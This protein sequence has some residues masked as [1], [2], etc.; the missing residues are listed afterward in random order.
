VNTVDPRRI[1]LIL[2]LCALAGYLAGYVSSPAQAVSAQTRADIPPVPN[3]PLYPDP[4]NKPRHWRLEDLRKIH[5]ARLAAQRAD[6]GRPTQGGGAPLPPGTPAFQGQR[7]RTHNIGTNFRWYYD[8]PRPANLTGV[9]SHYDDAEQHEG[10]S[11]FYVITGGG[12]QMVVD[13]EIENRQY[14]RAQAGAS[15]SL[16]LPGEFVGQPVKGGHTY[17]VKPGD[18]LAIPPNDPHWQIPNPN[19]GVS[20]LLLKVNVGLYP[21]SISR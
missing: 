5:E 11:D 15:N 13:G 14:R 3:P 16:L 7:F 20:Y 18:W 10:I 2:L 12:G 19:D 17:D 1:G 8:P 21:G 4:P 9:M 6:P